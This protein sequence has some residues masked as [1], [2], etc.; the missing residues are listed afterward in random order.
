MTSESSF[1]QADG[2]T[3][4]W[5]DICLLQTR[6]VN[7]IYT[8]ERYGRR[9]LLKTLQPKCAQLTEYRLQQEKEFRLGVALSHPNIATTYSLEEISPIGCCIVQE[10]IDGQTL[11]EWM[12]TKPSLRER[13]RVCEQLMSAL[14]YLHAHQLVH[15]DLK[16]SN[17]LITRNGNNVKLIDLGLSD[18]DDST[19]PVCQDAKDDICTLA[20]IL[21][22][23]FPHRYSWI[24]RRCAKGG[25]HNIE[26]LQKTWYRRQ[27][28]WRMMPIIL[29]MILLI[30]ASVLFYLAFQERQAEQRR[31]EKMM[32]QVNEAFDKHEVELRAAIDSA[33]TFMEAVTTLSQTAQSGWSVRDSLMAL[34]PENDP[35]RFQIFDIWTQRETKL[36]SELMEQA[37]AK[38]IQ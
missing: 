18:S 11:N 25:Y 29:A 12:Q 28:V 10:W 9:F 4:E 38:P 21:R 2:F 1:I 6:R 34:Y 20:P 8:G 30:I 26:V 19:N 35:I 7:V 31:L 32:S 36:Q 3:H 5:Q 33:A 37:Q 16:S 17:I 22:A 23:L 27:R 15:H 13:R 24:V 14:V